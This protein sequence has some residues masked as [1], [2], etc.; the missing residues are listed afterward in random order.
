MHA[1]SLAFTVL[2]ALAS[3]A[4]AGCSGGADDGDVQSDG[5][6][7]QTATTLRGVDSASVFSVAAARKLESEYGVKWTG[8]YIGGPCNGGASWNPGA[9]DAIS[10]A[11]KW[12]FLPIY[13]GQTSRVCGAHT[14]TSGQGTSDAHATAV[15]MK[16]FGWAANEK[17]PVVLD[18]EVQDYEDN[19]GG[20]ES[21]VRAW[22]N[23][24]RAEGYSPYVYTSYVAARAFAQAHIAIDAIWVASDFFA[25]F[26]NV[27]P[28]N[29]D[30]QNQLGDVFTSHNR[31]WQY[32]GAAPPV[33]IPGVGGIDCNVSDFPLAPAPSGGATGSGSS[34]GVAGATRPNGGGGSS[35]ST[36]ADACDKGNGFCTATL[37]CD[38]GHW[39][40]R[41]DDPAACTTVENVEEPCKE[42][43]GYCTATL[44]CDNGH[45]V[46]RANDPAACTSGPG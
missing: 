43:N 11:T 16:R 32:A 33:N 9:V 28:Y 2:G 13:V 40:P 26:A 44:Q 15:D 24:V 7:V 1:R 37:Q 3:F 36:A 29:H 45:W 20:T 41:Q 25:G 22:V 4:L 12:S 19:P 38:N 10:K 8:V 39:I 14:F 18:V 46:P 30:L 27:T 34:S 31:G 5:Q 35:G 21:Y 23:T 42:G 17:I 6:D